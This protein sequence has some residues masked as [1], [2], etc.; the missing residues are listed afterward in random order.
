MRFRIPELFLGALLA[1]AIFSMGILFSSQYPGQSTQNPPAEKSQ[2]T[3]TNKGEPKGFWETAATDP[4]AAFTLCLV[5]VG[6]LQA[7]LFLRQLKFIRDSLDDAKIVAISAQS[8]AETAKEQVAITKISVID[9]ERAYLAVGPTQ[10]TKD[11]VAHEPGEAES[12]TAVKIVVHNVG[13]TGA[14]ITKVYA[15]FSQRPPEGD[16]P[17]YSWGS[18]METDLSLGADKQSA[19]P[20]DFRNSFTDPQYF[21]GYIEYKDIFKTTRISRFCTFINPAQAPAFGKYDIAGS[22]GWR[23]NT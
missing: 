8:S 22:A 1:I 7:Y 20:I 5:F 13:R 4:V 14:I 9:L 23:E 19:L 2:Q 18:G 10:I 12:E 3:A 16:V 21:W 17:I 11:Y 15:E 6:G